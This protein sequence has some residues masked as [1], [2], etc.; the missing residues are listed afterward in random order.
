MNFPKNAKIEK[1]ASTDISRPSLVNPYLDVER[2]ALVATNGHAMVM[3]PVGI[4]DGDHAGPVSSEALQAARK[5]AGKSNDMASI[6]VNGAQVIPGGPTFPRPPE[7]EFPKYTAVIPEYPDECVRISF[8][9]WLLMQV[10][11]AMGVDKGLPIILTLASV[12]KSGT[13][14]PI[15]VTRDDGGAYGVIMP[16]RI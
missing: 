13:L 10:V 12:D 1:V 15:K 16:C 2:K 8:N 3:V 5:A 6:S 11:E 4:D 7:V 14:D 9:P